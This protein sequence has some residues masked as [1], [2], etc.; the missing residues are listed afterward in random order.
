MAADRHAESYHNA[1]IKL[2]PEEIFRLKFEVGDDAA[3]QRFEEALANLEA[4][5]V[6]RDVL[7]SIERYLVGA[8]VAGRPIATLQDVARALDC[9]LGDLV[10]PP[11]APTYSN[12]NTRAKQRL[13]F[14]FDL[15]P[16]NCT[17]NRNRPFQSDSMILVAAKVIQ[18]EYTILIGQFY[19]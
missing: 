12:A 7:L 14:I 17:S 3:K 18:N 19:F 5:G 9:A 2:D 15:T 16:L 11:P 13:R 1:H 8:R 10:R 6:D 4:L